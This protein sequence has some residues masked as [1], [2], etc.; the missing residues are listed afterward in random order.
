MRLLIDHVTPITFNDLSSPEEDVN[1]EDRRDSNYI[2]IFIGYRLCKSAFVI[3]RLVEIIINL[4]R[5]VHSQ[6]AIIIQR[7]ARTSEHDIDIP[8]LVNKSLLA[9]D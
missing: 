6:T 9:F 5:I 8:L 2:G 3:L 1:L 4:D 7:T